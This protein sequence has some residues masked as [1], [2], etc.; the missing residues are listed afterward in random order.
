MNNRNSR[1][2]EQRKRNNEKHLLHKVQWHAPTVP[3]SQE[4]EAGLRV[5]NFIPMQ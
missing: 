5:E 2:K 3:S 4:A 1:R